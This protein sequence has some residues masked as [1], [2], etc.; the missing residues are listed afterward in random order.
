MG[1]QNVQQFEGPYTML[2]YIIVYTIIYTHTDLL[3]DTDN[4]MMLFHVTV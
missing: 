2:L 1:I 4:K 3:N